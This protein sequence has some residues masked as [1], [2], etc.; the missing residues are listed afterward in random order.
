MIN[1]LILVG[2]IKKMPVYDLL[3]NDNELIVE[4]TRNYKNSDGVFEKDCFK[5]YLW[6]AISKKI[7]V[8]C[9]EGDLVAIRGRIVEDNE[10]Y[11]IV[12]EQVVLLNKNV[13]DEVFVR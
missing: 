10:C 6:F 1:Q 2:I 12:A 5:C 3:K 7:C 8:C 11:K 4:V 13:E 9:K